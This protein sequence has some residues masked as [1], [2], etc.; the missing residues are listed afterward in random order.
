[1]PG[2]PSSSPVGSTDPAEGAESSPAPDNHSASA[3]GLRSRLRSGWP[4]TATF[5][6]IPRVEIV[7]MAAAAGFDGVVCDL[8][9]GSMTA[10]DLPAL[11]AGAR[12]AGAYCIARTATRQETD[13]ARALDM[14][15][16][17][18]IVPHV[19]SRQAAEQV[20]AA[21]RFPPA[22]ER[23]LN[24][25]VAGTG[26]GLHHANPTSTAN[27]QVALVVMIEGA[28]ALAA[29]D[30]IA[31]VAEI[32]AI[33]IG[34]VDLAGSLGYPGNPEHPEVIAAI[35]QLIARLT[36]RGKPIGIYAP[37]AE[38][39]RRWLDQGA[40]L[41]VTSADAAMA[42]SAFTAMHAAIA[43]SQTPAPQEPAGSGPAGQ[44]AP[45]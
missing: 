16:D 28:D 36:S 27:A 18:V 21:G 15:A 1:M 7:E 10:A 25:Y 34:P 39:A 24:P 41:V 40:A 20:A 43:G 11:H 33:F 12:S 6:M 30:Q 44:P 19:D 23:S 35:R 38:A 37:T 45:L 3:A 13:I 14:G 29:A 26:Y 2:V 17:G 32:D 22:G 31:D 5:V 8:E 42:G 4:V 9:H